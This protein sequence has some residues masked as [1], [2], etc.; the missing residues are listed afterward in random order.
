MITGALLCACA[1]SAAV[2][3]QDAVRPGEPLRFETV[4]T[5]GGRYRID[6]IPGAGQVSVW[7]TL[8]LGS[9]HDPAGQPG[10][11]RV[12]GEVLRGEL[13]AATP[14]R[15]VEVLVTDRATM[16]GVLLEPAELGPLL[17]AVGRWLEGRLALDDDGLAKA[18]GRALLRADDEAAVLPGPML[19]E[20]AEAIL[21]AGEPIARP[22]AGQAERIRALG[23][24]AIRAGFAR[25]CHPS[26]ASLVLV[27][28]VAADDGELRGAL[29]RALAPAERPA[30]ACPPVAAADEE[31][32]GPA[33]TLSARVD[34]PFVAVG[35]AAPRWGEADYLPFLVG[36]EVLRARAAGT[37]QALRGGE[38]RAEFPPVGYDFLRMP[39]AAFVGRRGRDGD[40]VEAPAAEIESLLAGLR[41][42][43]AELPEI[44]SARAILL[45]T[46]DL[47]P[48]RPELREVVERHPVVLHQRGYVVACYGLHGWPADLRQAVGSVPHAEVDRLLARVL[49]PERTRRVALRPA[50]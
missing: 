36:M 43:G 7:L 16:V 27:G 44:Q 19:R 46:L 45:G 8:G 20:R 13:P 26:R 18:A 10:L 17:D 22:A 32:G 31:V 39:R 21:F 40:P 4:G 25:A 2:S 24:A 34:A 15:P 48:L 12:V 6:P 35:L 23:A 1:L 30:A 14:Q 11:A 9:D 42:G 47:P 29:A 49:A 41:A 3:P 37:F 33:E 38:V 5:G 50:R 28:A